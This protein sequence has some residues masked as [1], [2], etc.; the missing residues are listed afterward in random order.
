MGMWEFGNLGWSYLFLEVVYFGL[1]GFLWFYNKWEFILIGA[2]GMEV[3]G[4]KQFE[5]L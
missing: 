1:L 3:I 5:V 4:G 2:R